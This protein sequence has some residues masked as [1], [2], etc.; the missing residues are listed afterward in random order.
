MAS[1]TMT[2]ILNDDGSMSATNSNP[3]FHPINDG[4]WSVEQDQFSARGEDILDTLVQFSAPYSTT[5]LDGTWTTP[6][7][8]GTFV[9]TKQ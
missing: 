6:G 5:V 8:R 3:Q 4:T 7:A 9:V 2:M 1:S